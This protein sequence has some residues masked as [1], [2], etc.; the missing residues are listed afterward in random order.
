MDIIIHLNREQSEQL[1]L[2]YDMVDDLESNS[3]EEYAENLLGNLI[4]RVWHDVRTGVM[5]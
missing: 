5:S 4:E 1:R 2:L 3:I